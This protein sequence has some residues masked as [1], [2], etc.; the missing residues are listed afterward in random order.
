MVKLLEQLIS[1]LKKEDFTLDKSITLSV[2]FIIIFDRF[3]CLIRGFYK[4]IGLKR[5]G[6]VLFVGKNV[7][8]RFKKYIQLGNGVTLED[9]VLLDGL[10]KEGIIIGDN[11]KIGAYTQIKCTGSFRKIGKGIKIGRNSGIGDYCFFGAAGGIEIGENVIMGQNVRF[12]SE[13][14]NFDRVDIPIK[15]QGVTN[16]GIK[17]GNDCWI[18][19]GAVFL[20]GVTVG[21]GCVI[22]ANTLV[23]KDIPP[24]SV[25]VGNPVRIIKNRKDMV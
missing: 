21:D 1:R 7:K 17:V 10:S 6:K 20:D 23:N 2:L 9:F 5:C 12:H 24:Y 16:K 22:G 13:N 18:G 8:I 25:A 15:H 14:H 4:R 11:V 3:K 19:A